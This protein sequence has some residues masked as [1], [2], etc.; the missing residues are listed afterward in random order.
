[1][2]RLALLA[3][4]TLAQMGV[5][6]APV[7]KGPAPSF[8]VASTTEGDVLKIDPSGN[9]VGRLVH[10]DMAITMVRLS[11]DSSRILMAA[12]AKPNKTTAKM[13]LRDWKTD[14]VTELPEAQ[15]LAACFWL[16]DGKSVAA[17]GLN[18]ALGNQPQMLRHQCWESWTIETATKKVTRL[19]LDGEF[20]IIGFG[21]DVKQLIAART[22]DP[23]PVGNGVLSPRIET[24]VVD[25]KSLKTTL[26]I[27]PELDVVPVAILPDGRNW[28]V[29][30]I[31]GADQRHRFGLLDTHNDKFTEFPNQAVP[32]DTAVPSPDGKQIL[33]SQRVRTDDGK[34]TGAL[35][36]IDVDGMKPRKFFKTSSVITSIDWVMVRT[37]RG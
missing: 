26:A 17:S 2:T 31:G 34:T 28:I 23:I 10:K 3:S 7:P 22:F 4:I 13:F 32:Y 20:R 15:H 21:T 16:P 25:R 29:T 6:A 11:P 36:L 37:P 19:E 5:V 1:M 12:R 9:E 30:K 27:K 14:T 24:H 18:I 8:I 35:I 33:A